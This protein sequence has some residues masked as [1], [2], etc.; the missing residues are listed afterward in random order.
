MKNRLPAPINQEH[1]NMI[2]QRLPLIEGNSIPTKNDNITTA[3]RWVLHPWYNENES[4]SLIFDFISSVQ[5]L[6]NTVEC[7]DFFDRD[8]R[9]FQCTINSWTWW[10]SAE[11]FFLDYLMRNN[12][13]N[14]SYKLNH[15]KW[16]HMIDHIIKADFLSTIDYTYKWYTI[17][18]IIWTQLNYKSKTY[19]HPKPSSWIEWKERDVFQWI[20][21]GQRLLETMPESQRPQIPCFVRL[22]STL[23]FEEN[24]DTRNWIFSKAIDD[25]WS[26][27]YH[28]WWPSEHMPKK[29]QEQLRDMSYFYQKW[30]VSFIRFIYSLYGKHQENVEQKTYT[31]HQNSLRINTYDPEMR[32]SVYEFFRKSDKKS[33]MKITFRITDDMHHFFSSLKLK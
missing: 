8:L 24:D 28:W 1:I 20:T 30:C 5:K 33:F 18:H 4:T 21:R 31:E 10:K 12:H 7:Y 13:Q 11:Y 6:R 9:I 14:W 3:L 2:R 25:R 32:R 27:W 23:L 17:P 29:Y 15:M 19:F 22:N 26:H 16:A